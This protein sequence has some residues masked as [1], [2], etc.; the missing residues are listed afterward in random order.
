MRWNHPTRGWVSPTEFIPLA[1]DSGLIVP[2]GAWALD[3]ACRQLREWEDTVGNGTTQHLKVSVNLSARQ[4]VDEG[5]PSLVAGTLARHGV[6][7]PRLILEITETMMIHDVAATVRRLREL[8]SLGVH[9]AVD[10][11][12]T[13]FS[14]LGYL[15]QFPIDRIKIDKSFVDQLHTAQGRA[16]AEGILSL[17]RSLDLE[18]IAEGIEH[19]YQLDAL[20]HLGCQLGQGYHLARP[21]PPDVVTQWLVERDRSSATHFPA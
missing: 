8:K 3:E 6:A 17:A 18:A 16:L 4:L 12:G 19:Q 13:G 11:F 9:L 5:F 21:A 14:S 10:D 1:E 2:L 15:S 7:A 20:D